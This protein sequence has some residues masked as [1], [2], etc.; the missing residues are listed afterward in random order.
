MQSIAHKAKRER[1]KESMQQRKT[2][3]IGEMRRLNGDESAKKVKRHEP[4]D[5]NNG[6]KKTT[7]SSRKI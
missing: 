2:R 6:R 3:V 5:Q 4:T 1:K 7:I